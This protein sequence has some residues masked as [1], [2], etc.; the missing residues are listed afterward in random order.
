MKEYKTSMECKE[1]K[2]A[3]YYYQTK[4]KIHLQNL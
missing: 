3:S 4:S 1:K 2:P